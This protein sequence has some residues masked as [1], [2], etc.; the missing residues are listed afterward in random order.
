MR[1]LTWL[2]LLG[3]VLLLPTW[4]HAQETVKLTDLTGT[5][6]ATTRGGL[7]HLAGNTRGVLIFWVRGTGTHNTRLS[8]YAPDPVSGADQLIDQLTTAQTTGSESNCI[9]LWPGDLNP[10]TASASG[11][12]SSCTVVDTREWAVFPSFKLELSDVGT[13]ASAVNTL[14]LVPLQ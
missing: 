13:M 10:G 11:A 5:F 12:D 2:A 6:S 14:Y 3:A 8:L 7:I 4:A 9:W 1:R